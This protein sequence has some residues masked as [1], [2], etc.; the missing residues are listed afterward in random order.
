MVAWGGGY[1]WALFKVHI[2]VNQGNPIS[3]TILN[4][5]VYV[6]LHHWFSVV[7]EA[8]GGGRNGSIWKVHPKSVGILLFR[9]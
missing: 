1:F 7:V 2:G 3:P 5:V 6:V 9:R 8:E 4:V